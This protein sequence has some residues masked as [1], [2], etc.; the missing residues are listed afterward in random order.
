MTNPM[1]RYWEQPATDKILVDGEVALME[2]ST[3]EQL[4]EYSASIPTG[5]YPGKMWR[6]ND[7][8]YDAQ[9]TKTVWMLGWFGECPDP[10]RCSVNFLP[11]IFV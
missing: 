5:V 3:F 6:R 1:G 9:A 11:I 4:S 8:I 7:G 2:R 10:N